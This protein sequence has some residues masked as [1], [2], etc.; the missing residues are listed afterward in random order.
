[1]GKKTAAKLTP[2]EKKQHKEEM[3]KVM[4]QLAANQK[5]HGENVKML[6]PVTDIHLTAN[7][8]K[9][10]GIKHKKLPKKK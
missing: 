8:H 1:M 6:I 5:T 9:H 2:Q 7:K 3:K 10:T 4:Q